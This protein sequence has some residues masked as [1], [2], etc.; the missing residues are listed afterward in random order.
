MDPRGAVR[1]PAIQL[2]VATGEGVEVGATTFDGI[3]G[4]R[5]FGA[6][7]HVDPV[8]VILADR[9]GCYAPVNWDDTL[10]NSADRH[11]VSRAVCRLHAGF[12][13]ATAIGTK[14]ILRGVGKRTL[15]L[16][17]GLR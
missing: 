16:R 13:A 2:L 7:D 1:V 5:A 9:D 3:I 6:I 8:D 15:R 14:C 12:Q 10:A 17:W 11:F 4:L